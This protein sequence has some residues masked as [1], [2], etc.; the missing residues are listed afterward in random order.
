MKNLESKVDV[1]EYD[2]VI[3]RHLLISNLCF[4]HGLFWCSSKTGEDRR[5]TPPLICSV[6]IMEIDADVNTSRVL[7]INGVM[8]HVES[9]EILLHIYVRV[10]MR[11]PLP[12]SMLYQYGCD[13]RH[14]VRAFYHSLPTSSQQG[15]GGK[16]NKGYEADCTCRNAPSAR[17]SSATHAQ[18]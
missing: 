8:L 6:C 16:T 12:M 9:E 1:E 10:L 7:A 5:A 18:V 2:A 14:L 11:E 4:V 13:A 15:F 3:D 17:V